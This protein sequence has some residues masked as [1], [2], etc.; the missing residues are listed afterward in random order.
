MPGGGRVSELSSQPVIDHRTVP[1]TPNARSSCGS[2]NRRRSAIISSTLRRLSEK[3][4]YQR[5]ASRDDFRFKM[6]SSEDGWPALL[7][8]ITLKTEMAVCNT[9]VNWE[10]RPRAYCHPKFVRVRLVRVG[11]EEYACNIEGTGHDSTRYPRAAR[12]VSQ[13]RSHFRR[14]RRHCAHSKA[15]AKQKPRAPSC[16]T[17]PRE[18]DDKTDDR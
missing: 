10:I 1:L 6:A 9:S 11:E 18:R 4:K 13:Y 7:H 16:R 2:T 3:R 15:E 17:S 5:D 8:L 14:R 12:T